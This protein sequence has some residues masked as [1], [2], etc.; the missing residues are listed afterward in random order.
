MN[1]ISYFAMNQWYAAQHQPPHLAALCIWEGAADWYREI[2][3]HGG[4]YSQFLDNLFPRAFHRPQNGLGE[5]GLRSRVT[6]ELV[7][8]PATLSEQELKRNRIDIGKPILDHRFVDDVSR[9]RTP[10]F[11][12]VK[13]PL[14]SAANWGGQGLHPRGN[15]EGFLDAASEQKWLEVQGDA[16]WSHFY[17]DYGLDLQKRFFAKF[18]KG[19]DAAWDSQPKVLLQVRHPG[20]RFV[21]RHENEWPLQRTQ[22]TKSICSRTAWALAPPSLG[23]RPRCHL[24]RSEKA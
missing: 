5:R 8:G 3:R 11:S 24:R 16:H 14:L 23:Q 9:A 7:S 18:L 13:T 19:N 21:E 22:W 6:G 12:K 2:A 17:S 1:G 10:D 4:I 20:E 15:F